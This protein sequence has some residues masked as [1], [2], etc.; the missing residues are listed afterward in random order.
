[1]KFLRYILL[2]AVGL[3][4]FPLFALY[5][6]LLLPIAVMDEALFEKLLNKLF[7]RLDRI[8]FRIL[9]MKPKF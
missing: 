2:Y 7:R 8:R 5:L 9:G 3:V 6:L 4:F 1:M